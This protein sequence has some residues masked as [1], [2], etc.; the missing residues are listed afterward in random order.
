MKS[1]QEFGLFSENDTI[2][3]RKE[4]SIDNLMKDQDIIEVLSRLHLKRE[5][6]EEN[7]I[8]FLDYQE[9][10]KKCKLCK[11]IKDCTKVSIGMKQNMELG[12]SGQILISLS[13]CRFGSQILEN[14]RILSHILLKNVSEELL[15]TTSSKIKDVATQDPQPTKIIM[16]YIQ[17]PQSTGLYIYGRPGSGKSSLAGFIIRNLAKKEKRCGFIHFPTFLMDLKNSFGEEGNNE[18]I[19]LLKNLDYLVI[20][21]IGGKNVTNWSRDEILSSTLAYRNQNNKVTF[22]TSQYSISQ[23][24]SLYMLK[25]GDKLRVERLLD[26]MKAVSQEIVLKG[27]DLR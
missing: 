22:F 11:G 26:R 5:D 8:E 19:E 12:E 23:L 4:K 25:Q 20:D 1:I 17:N 14:Q 27:S 10:L 3:K 24:K 6:I 13:P 18:T 21:D 2:L 16:N 9:D 15:L 7:W